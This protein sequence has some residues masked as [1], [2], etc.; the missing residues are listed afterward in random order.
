[1]LRIYLP[2]ELRALVSEVPNADSFEWDIGT[3]SLPGLGIGLTHL[4]GIPKPGA[5]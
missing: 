4:V 2:D 5:R 3:M 1:M